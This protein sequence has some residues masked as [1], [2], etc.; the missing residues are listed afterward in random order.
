MSIESDCFDLQL[1]CFGLTAVHAPIGGLFECQETRPSSRIW[2]S[3]ARR[4]RNLRPTFCPLLR[5]AFKIPRCDMH[6][7]LKR[8]D[9]GIVHH[10]SKCIISAPLLAAIAR[11][12][13]A[14]ARRARSRECFSCQCGK[15]RGFASAH[16]TAAIVLFGIARLANIL[17][18][19]RDLYPARI[20]GIS[21]SSRVFCPAR[22]FA[23][24]APPRP[25]SPQP[26]DAGHVAHP[27]RL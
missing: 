14:C 4:L 22:Q 13:V 27:P 24:L 23:D 18:R 10:G 7:P 25:A 16:S 20:A 5:P 8:L 11:D 21:S 9:C 3:S 6:W 19:Q 17:V 1:E 15:N 12:A 26:V 2:A